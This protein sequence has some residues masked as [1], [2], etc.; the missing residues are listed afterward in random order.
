MEYQTGLPNL[1][2]E[3][4]K[5]YKIYREHKC[6]GH[7]SQEDNCRVC[8]A[9]VDWV[10]GYYKASLGEKSYPEEVKRKLE[11][12]L[13][14]HEGSL[15]SWMEKR[16]WARAKRRIQQKRQW[17]ED[18]KK[19]N[20]TQKSE[21]MEEPEVTQKSDAIDVKLEEKPATKTTETLKSAKHQKSVEQSAILGPKA[22]KTVTGEEKDTQK[23][24]VEGEKVAEKSASQ[25]QVGQKPPTSKKR[26]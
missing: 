16:D 13:Y 10:E 8:Q 26:E 7:S 15:P 11:E 24:P 1:K 9:F 20:A 23:S 14:E 2:D 22:Q 18:E 5:V 12:H 4:E 21:K 6:L 19:L 17:P 25:G 3:Y